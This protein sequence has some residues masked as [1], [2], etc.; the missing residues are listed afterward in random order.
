MNSKQLLTSCLCITILV[1][2]STV[3]ANDDDDYNYGNDFGYG[4][5][6]EDIYGEEGSDSDGKE[7]SEDKGDYSFV[8]KVTGFHDNDLE[9]I[10]EDDS[11]D[12]EPRRA[13]YLDT[14]KW[15]RGGWKKY[16][17]YVII[18]GG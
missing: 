4:Y 9:D 7:D 8:H 3:K 2:A 1:S 5:G 12:F 13:P 11:A 6:G 14:W 16:P 17:L 10:E 15:K 18:L